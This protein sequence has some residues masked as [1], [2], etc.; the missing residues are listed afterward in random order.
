MYIVNEHSDGMKFVNLAMHTGHDRLGAYLCCNQFNI[1]SR[2]ARF[3]LKPQ[4]S[5]NWSWLR[6]GPDG[7]F[8]EGDTATALIHLA[9]LSKHRYPHSNQDTQK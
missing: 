8:D 3:C 6:E 2:T 7:T 5:T 9:T 4:H 1:N